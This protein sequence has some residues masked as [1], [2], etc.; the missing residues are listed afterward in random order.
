MSLRHSDAE[1]NAGPESSSRTGPLKADAQRT[2]RLAEPPETKSRLQKPKASTKG[3]RSPWQWIV[4]GV[5]AATLLVPA[6]VA[7]FLYDDDFAA[8]NDLPRATAAYR[9]TGL[10]WTPADLSKPVPD[11]ENA[12]PELKLALEQMQ[13]VDTDSIA[14]CLNSGDLQTAKNLAQL[15]DPA[16]DTLSYAVKKPFADWKH[17]WKLGPLLTLPELANEKLLVKAFSLRARIRAKEG[18]ANGAADDLRAARRLAAFAGQDPILIGLLVQIAGE[19]LA[20]QAA[21]EAAAS[22][23]GDADALQRLREAVEMPVDEPNFGFAMRGEA[24][25]AVTIGRNPV[26]QSKGVIDG[27][28]GAPSVDP[29]SLASDGLPSD[30]RARATMDRLLEVWGE[31]GEF[32]KAHPNDPEALAGKMEEIA[33]SLE[34]KTSTSY[35]VAKKLFPV[36]SQAANALLRTQALDRATDALLGAMIEHARTGRYPDS[37]D[38]IPGKWIDPFTGGPLH[39]RVM[40]GNDGFRVYSFGSEKVDHGGMTSTELKDGSN[41]HSDVVA[42]Y[43]PPKR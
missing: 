33:K 13:G 34:S 41:D 17:D 9:Q 11:S 28:A 22:F 43:P 35:Q 21:E 3:H 20:L 5:L 29:R 6:G 8:S 1:E 15:M 12:A 31:Y 30:L 10:P 19:D 38:E 7:F 40:P 24:F 14:K 23:S 18:N 25:N 26:F 42:S 2:G 27:E 39:I 16:L 37:I 36:F 32:A 4:G